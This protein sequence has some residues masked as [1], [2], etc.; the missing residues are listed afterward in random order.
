MTTFVYGSSD[1]LI[2]F[3]GDIYDELYALNDEWTYL[4]FSNGLLAKVKYDGE[5]IIRGVDAGESADFTLH[6]VGDVD[7]NEF[8]DYTDVLE[9]HDKVRWVV[10][11]AKA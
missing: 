6:H 4:A 8:N 7:A 5:W 2:S 1:D 11:G 9:I 10:A 3:H